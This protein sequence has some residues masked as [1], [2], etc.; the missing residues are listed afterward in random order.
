M[1]NKKTTAAL[2]G[3]FGDVVGEVIT[4]Q[5]VGPCRYYYQTTIDGT[6]VN[7]KLGR[8]SRSMRNLEKAERQQDPCG[9]YLCKSVDDCAAE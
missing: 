2:I 5:P 1:G 7:S 4:A 3:T 9:Y 6:P 8:L